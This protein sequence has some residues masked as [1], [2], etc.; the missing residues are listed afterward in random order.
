[1]K[2]MLDNCESCIT[3][4]CQIGCPLNN[5][6]TGFIKELK[7]NNIENAFDLLN[8]T[9]VLMPICGRICPHMKQCQRSCVKGVSYTPVEIGKLETIVGDAWL[10]NDYKINSPQKTHH[11][12]AVI[13]A[14]PAGLT[15]AAFSR[16]A[17][18]A[19]TIYEKKDYLGG[20]LVHGIPEFRLPKEIVK[21]LTSK[22]IEL[23][24]EVKYNVSLG[25]DFSLENLQKEY[26]AIFI[27]VGANKSNKMNIIGEDTN[28]VFGGNELLENKTVLDL[29]GKTVIISGGG[30]VAMDVSRTIKKQG[31]KEVIVVYRRSKNEMPAEEKEVEEALEEGIKFNFLTNIE[32]IIGNNKVEKIKISKNELIK[33]EGESRLS[34]QKIEGSENYISCDYVIM[35]VGSHP[36]ECIEKLEIEKLKGKINIDKNGK[37]NIDKVYAGGD[38]TNTKGTVAWA[39]RSGRN[40]AYEI[41]KELEG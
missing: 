2:K 5:D 4:P 7:S 23:G 17:G 12:V 20:L 35:A 24:I 9:S 26:D 14:G 31:A 16:R 8:K 18:I 19:V 29:K 15:C 25:V 33:K 36:D 41:I 40:A 32:E 34:P 28:G 38:V 11:K 10:E 21:K 3:K 1:M 22:I 37:T 6:T 30:N 27:G 39:S 13:G